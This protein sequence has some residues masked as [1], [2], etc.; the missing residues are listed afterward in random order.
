M[1]KTNCNSPTAK[2]K[3]NLSQKKVL[4][5]AKVD[6]EELVTFR[7][8][9]DTEEDSIPILKINNSES[10]IKRTRKLPKI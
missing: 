10:L 6:P 4:G 5:L 2:H 1:A 8:F 7:N 9:I 3:R